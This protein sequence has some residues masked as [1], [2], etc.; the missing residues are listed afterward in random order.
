MPDICISTYLQ[1][2]HG[3]RGVLVVRP[4]VGHN[5]DIHIQRWNGN[6]KWTPILERRRPHARACATVLRVR[7]VVKRA[8]KL[9]SLSLS[10]EL[11][12]MHATQDERERES[13]G[14]REEGERWAKRKK[15]KNV[16][17]ERAR[18]KLKMR[19]RTGAEGERERGRNEGRE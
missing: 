9:R 19:Q 16:S 13:R 15:W 7:R 8:Q 1:C 3:N 11:V 12:L 14:G 6:G 17:G 10:L 4:S 2:L 5:M 18:A